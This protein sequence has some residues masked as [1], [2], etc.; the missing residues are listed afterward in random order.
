MSNFLTIIKSLTTAQIVDLAVFFGFI[1]F[2]IFIGIW[3][4]R[5][6]KGET[7]NSESYF[8]AGR[9]LSWW[10][11][12]FS[13]IAANISTEQFVGMSGSAARP[14]GLAI[15]GYEWIAAVSL[16]IV[17]FLCLP[18]FLRCGI[19]TIP[20]FLEK[21]FGNTSRLLMSI[22]MVIVLVCVNITVVIYSGAKMLDV[23][24]GDYM[25]L[26]TACWL[27]GIVSAIYVLIGGLK[28]CA[29]ADLLQGSALILGG[30]I[31]LVLALI[32]FNRADPEK[33]A[34]TPE[35]AQQIENAP[36]LTKFKTVNADR[37]HTIRPKT[38][39]SVPWTALLIG[40]WIPNLYYWGLN[41]YI[42]QRALGSKSLA[43]GQGG[44]VFAASL[45][46]LIPFIV[47]FPGMMALNL[48]M[49][50]RFGYEQNMQSEA[51]HKANIYQVVAFEEASG[52]DLPSFDTAE[53]QEKDKKNF[54]LAVKEAARTITFKFNDDFASLYS[55]D[56]KL[57]TEYNEKIYRSIGGDTAALDE[58]IV[59]VEGA[60]LEKLQEEKEWNLGTGTISEAQH[61]RL[62]NKAILDLI[63]SMH[64]DK[65]TGTGFQ[66]MC[67]GFKTQ[68][69]KN[70]DKDLIKTQ[71]EMVGYDYDAAFPLLVSNLVKKT[72]YYGLNGF[73]LAAMMGAVMSSL[74]SMLN[75]AATIFS[76]DLV[77]RHLYKGITERGLVFLGRFLTLTFVVIGC[78]IAPPLLGDPRFGGVF[79]FIQEFQGFISP[80]IL[81]IFIFGIFYRN[82]PSACG[83]V[84]MLVGPLV[85]GI[86]MGI[87]PHMAFLD[88]M[89]ITFGIVYALLLQI[90]VMFPRKEPFRFEQNTSIDLKS[91]P[92]AMVVGFLVVAT[93][94]VFYYVLR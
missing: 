89:A 52:I 85:Y 31:I 64:N 19:Y 94:A 61:L 56:A 2:V 35:M 5:E 11:I 25:S 63:D 81:A 68:F 23:S 10:L 73:I 70:A 33:L 6:K 65:I 78:L 26:T 50:G 27:V 22:A 79:H 32:A 42:M 9:G 55:D 72:K 59:E 18:I 58:K 83:V 87:A 57:I 17:A 53:M 14:V 93:V 30:A 82:A 12:G 13:L 46:L 92:L 40:I 75:A 45:K 71:K 74:A 47:I 88:R 49:D 8:L 20:E 41:Q 28:A 76:M 54:D 69:D 37:L 67:F 36:L 66:K 80:G 15:A 86:L 24:L 51:K 48:F 91:S 21:R 16:V 62:R 1:I 84:G 44:V 38:D 90:T 43:H 7:E 3:M 39:D 29:W 77:K 60:E 4:S 34:K